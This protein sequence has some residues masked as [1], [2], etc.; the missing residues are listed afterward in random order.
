MAWLYE[1][2]EEDRSRFVLGEIADPCS[3]TLLCFGINPS[4]ATLQK[5]DQ[6]LKSTI[7]LAHFNGY[8]NWVMLNIYPQR[9]TDPN[10][11]SVSED[12]GLMQ[13]NLLHIRNLLQ[14]YPACDVLFAYG[15]LISKRK[16]LKTCLQR[17]VDLL[18]DGF[19][20]D[21]LM[22]GRTKQ[23]NPRHPLY[24]KTSKFLPYTL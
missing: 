12:I 2:D 7:R 13:T 22:I 23:G 11:L 15:N 10:D 3:R 8:K 24:A 9:A 14:T 19:Q 21:Y 18:Q 16:Y 17:I 1:T 5:F 20:G 6:T 4:T